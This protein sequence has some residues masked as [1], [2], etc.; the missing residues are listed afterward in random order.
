[1]CWTTIIYEL[2]IFSFSINHFSREVVMLESTGKK[3]NETSELA[4]ILDSEGL[5][6]LEKQSTLL[7]YFQETGVAKIKGIV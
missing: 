3:L 2:C 5:K 7:S 4:K 6:G 1:M